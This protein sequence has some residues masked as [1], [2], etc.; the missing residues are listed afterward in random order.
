MEKDL[1]I[2]QHF[3]EH[4]LEKYGGFDE[5][6]KISADRDFYMKTIVKDKISFSYFPFALSVF[7]EGGLSTNPR[8]KKMI[9]HEDKIIVGLYY[10]DFEKI[11]IN[12][13]VF[14]K[15]FSKKYLCNFLLTLLNWKLKRI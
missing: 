14:R 2:L 6:F 10:S 5:Q 15:L 7:N 11:L 9:E 4:I 8:Y 12:L 13:K 1:A 3:I